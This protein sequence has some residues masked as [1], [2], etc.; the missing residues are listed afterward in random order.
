M[1]YP[2]I[3]LY[4]A[5]ASEV[6]PAVSSGTVWSQQ[7][8]TLPALKRGCHVVTRNFTEKLPELQ[9][10]EIGLVSKQFFCA[11]VCMHAVPM[12][13]SH[14]FHS[15]YCIK[16]TGGCETVLWMLNDMTAFA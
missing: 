15:M 7:L 2:L 3:L 12:F 6:A 1:C 8:V 4:V 16:Q 9:E 14:H 5:S 13:V 10:Y 11:M